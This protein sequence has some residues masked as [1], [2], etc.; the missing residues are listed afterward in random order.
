M[1]V[2]HRVWFE[3]ETKLFGKGPVALLKLIDETQSLREAARRLDLSYTKAFNLIK[4]AEKQLG[5][6]LLKRTI[7]GESGGG[8]RLSEQAYHLIDKYEAI[9]RA[10][11]KAASNALEEYEQTELLKEL[12]RYQEAKLISVI[13]GGGK[14]T[15]VNFLVNQFSKIGPTLLTSTTAMFRPSGM[16]V[17]FGVITS[18]GNPIALFLE[19][20]REDKLKGIPPEEV[21]A[22]K[23]QG[24]FSSVIVEADG[25]KGLPL[26]SY[27]AHEPPIPSLSDVVFL[28]I[29]LD[30]FYQP[31]ENVVHRPDVYRRLSE[32]AE[33]VVT[34]ENYLKHFLHPEGSLK[35]CPDVPI[36]V[37]L[38]RVD[39][40]TDRSFID[41]FIQGLFQAKRVETVFL[42]NLLA[43]RLE[44]AFHRPDKEE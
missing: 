34:V 39:T 10:V 38:N 42:T 35:N 2:S 31:I 14:T 24:R 12:H 6:P 36:V 37:V 28:V 23:Q 30:G 11:A 26:K 17:D 15:L 27:E 8:S 9:E 43:G 20:I 16:P 21:D 13:G 5:Y 25:S 32:A 40:L 1:K 44:Q 18:V 41:T 33:D 29:G 3:H 7:G 22:L 19:Q 4:S